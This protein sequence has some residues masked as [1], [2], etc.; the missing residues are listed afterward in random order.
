MQ[1]RFFDDK[2]SINDS[3]T[4]SDI[5]DSIDKAKAGIKAAGIKVP[6]PVSAAIDVVKSIANPQPTTTDYI[7][8]K[9]KDLAENAASNTIV[10]GVGT[11]MMSAV[12]S[13]AALPFPHPGIKVAAGV[14]GFLTGIASQPAATEVS[15]PVGQ[16]AENVC[17]KV[18]DLLNL[19]GSK[20]D[21]E[22]PVT[23]DIS[24]TNCN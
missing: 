12:E 17:R 8:G 2:N 9:V 22:V 6:L 13:A 1:D 3:D 20:S 5:K 24:K 16:A 14:A 23:D 4:N 18:A 10:V 19:D 15:K 11:G 21:H 7:C